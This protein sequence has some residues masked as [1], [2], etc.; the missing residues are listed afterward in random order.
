LFS[1]IAACVTRWLLIRLPSYLN[2]SL[3]RTQMSR[4]SDLTPAVALGNPRAASLHLF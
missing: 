3:C 2:K 1:V 4:S